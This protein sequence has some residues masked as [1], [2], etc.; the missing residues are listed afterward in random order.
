MGVDFIAYGI[1]TWSI[2]DA[3]QQLLVRLLHVTCEL[4]N[5]KSVQ[6]LTVNQ[7]AENW[8]K[9]WL[10]ESFGV[11]GSRQL[12]SWAIAGGLAY[13]LW[14]LP[15]VREEERRKVRADS[16]PESLRA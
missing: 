13:Y 1:C 16:I 4:V 15:Q 6:T 5:N 2:L 7:M 12:A 3:H 14:Y 8:V 11:R 9:H 10:S